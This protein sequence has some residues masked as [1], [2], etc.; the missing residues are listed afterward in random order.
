[1]K[2]LRSQSHA[3]AAREAE[4]GMCVLRVT[5]SIKKMGNS[6]QYALLIPHWRGDPYLSVRVRRR[7]RA[8]MCFPR[9]LAEPRAYTP[10][11]AV[12]CSFMDAVFVRAAF[13]GA[14][15]SA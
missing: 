3:A 13:H 15:T 6:F 1:M 10:E 8:S 14:S 7:T 9:I 12:R 4:R 2:L 5:L 11:H